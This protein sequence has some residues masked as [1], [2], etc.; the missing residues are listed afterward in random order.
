M[1]GC[2]IQQVTLS[3]SDLIRK[4]IIAGSGTSEPSRNSDIRG[5]IWPQESPSPEPITALALV[6]TPEETQTSLAPSFFY[7]DVAGKAQFAK[8]WS[9]IAQRYVPCEPNNFSFV[10]VETSKRQSAA[11]VDWTIPNPNNAYD[12]LGK[13]RIQVLVVNRD[14]DVLIPTSASWEMHVKIP[15]SEL[16]LYPRA[17]HGFIWQYAELFANDPRAFLD[18]ED[19]EGNPAQM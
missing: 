17:G 15:N 13:L 5:I 11:N 10:D 7:D 12:R 14:H 9:R 4:L 8:Y 18:G 1:G 3:A 16:I 2:A 19:F 6:V